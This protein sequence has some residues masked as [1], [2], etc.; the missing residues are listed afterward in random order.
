MEGETKWKNSFIAKTDC[1]LLSLPQSV[2]SELIEFKGNIFVPKNLEIEIRHKEDITLKDLDVQQTLGCGA[3]GRVKL[4]QHKISKRYFALKCLIKS[5]I[6]EK[7]LKQHI[8]NEKEVR[9]H[10]T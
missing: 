5:H 1:T 8:Y 9:R 2:F 3:F 6:V 7:G 4:V 10:K